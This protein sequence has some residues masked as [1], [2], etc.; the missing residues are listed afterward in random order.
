MTLQPDQSVVL[1]NDDALHLPA[2][3]LALP[4]NARIII[5]GRSLVRLTLAELSVPG[6]EVVWTDFRQSASLSALHGTLQTA[7][8][9]DRMILAADGDE[10]EAM[11]ALMCAV[12]TF[13][14]ALRRRAGARV[15]LVV[16][17][18]RAVSSLV[19]FIDR[20]RPRMEADGITLMVQILTRRV[21][22][23]A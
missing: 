11:F 18:G 1:L 20:L 8:G 2:G 9:L 12:L 14:P 23:A 22:A 17:R 5:A 6:A 4:E 19:Q 3:T 13:L 15:E 16:E 7:G 10:S 21:E